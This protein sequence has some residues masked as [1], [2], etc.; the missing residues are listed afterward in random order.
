MMTGWCGRKGQAGPEERS[1]VPLPL[2][3]ASSPEM[4]QECVI[5]FSGKGYLEHWNELTS[6]RGVSGSKQYQSLL[7]AKG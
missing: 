6:P 1:G 5:L 4:Y 2:G 7:E 3:A